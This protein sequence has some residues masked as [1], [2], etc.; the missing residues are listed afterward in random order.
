MWCILSVASLELQGELA[1]HHIYLKT[2][3]GR[4]NHYNQDLL[5]NLRESGVQGA[6]FWFQALGNLDTFG[7]LVSLIGLGTHEVMESFH[8]LSASGDLIALALLVEEGG[9]LKL[10]VRLVWLIL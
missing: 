7:D 1:G 3:Q 4:G 10:P 9:F 2:Q 5:R 6:L 8:D